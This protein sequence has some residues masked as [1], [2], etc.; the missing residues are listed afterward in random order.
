MSIDQAGNSSGFMSFNGM[1]PTSLIIPGS[2]VV[3]VNPDCTGSVTVGN[4]TSGATE[5]DY[6]FFDRDTKTMTVSVIKIAIGSASALGTWKQISRN[7]HAASWP[8]A[9]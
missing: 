3:K 7:T 2:G 4:P 6:F 1:G 9:Q 8:P 5:T